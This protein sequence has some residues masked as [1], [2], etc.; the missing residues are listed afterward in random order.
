MSK[1]KFL[2]FALFSFLAA[3]APGI[4]QVHAADAPPH[5]NA[6]GK[7]T[8][9]PTQT[10][11]PAPVKTESKPAPASASKPAPAPEPSADSLKEMQKHPAARSGRGHF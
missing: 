8:P 11:A 5:A 2:W 3:S 4:A 7:E 6:K 9:V 10:K 1:P